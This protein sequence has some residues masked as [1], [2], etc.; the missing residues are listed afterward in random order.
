MA[1]ILGGLVWIVGG[2]LGWGANVNPVAY[3]VG[4]GW[5]L[6]AFA[7]FGYTLVDHAPV[8][9]RGIV[10]LA[11]PALAYVVWMSVTDAFATDSPPA[12]GAGLLL[13][14]VGA[15]AMGRGGRSTAAAPAHVPVRGRRAAR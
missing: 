14:V 10:S 13:L 9:L 2:V 7:A 11:T 5:F 8:W 6:V 12:L 3:L 15:V 4:L 1:A